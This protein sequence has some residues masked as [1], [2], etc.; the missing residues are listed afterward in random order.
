MAGFES[1]QGGAQ[2]RVPPPLVFAVA[3]AVGWLLPG[4]R[5]HGHHFARVALGAGLVA[6]ALAL[7][8]GALGLFRRTGQDPAPWQPTPQLVFDG[9]FRYTRNPM[10][11]GLTLITLGVAAL[12]GH[13]FIALLA[14]AALGAV[15]FTAVLPEERYLAGKFGESYTTYTTKV[16]RYL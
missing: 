12:A 4:L 6:V 7:I 16:R 8:V 1:R 9:P 14:F 13:G 3:I 15:H 5:V 10:Y 2:V 11:V